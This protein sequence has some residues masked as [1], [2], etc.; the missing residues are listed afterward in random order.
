MITVVLE[1][2]KPALA[3]LA[4][5]K[6]NR[7]MDV[8][9]LHITMKVINTTM[10]PGVQVPPG[11][12]VRKMDAGDFITDNG[13]SVL[14]G[15]PPDP[16]QVVHCEEWIKR[17]GRPRKSI[18]FRAHSYTLKHVAENWSY[19]GAV[20]PDPRGYVTNGAFILAAL[21]LGY[22]YLPAGH[23]KNPNCYFN[24][25][26][27]KTKKKWQDYRYSYLPWD[28]EQSSKTYVLEYSEDHHKRG[29][30]PFHISTKEISDRRGPGPGNWEVIDTGTVDEMFSACRKK[31]KELGVRHN[32]NS[33]S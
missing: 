4:V 21:N 18:N 20:W 26:F 24:M 23:G 28:D 1:S 12:N 11:A 5:Q 16:F 17:F 15:E 8:S 3:K 33:N 30:F 7:S 10:P 13:I 32:D 22:K 31:Y 6:R 29:A 27:K 9:Y 14:P 25:A 19:D 2:T